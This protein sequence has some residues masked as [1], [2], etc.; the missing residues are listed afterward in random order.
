MGAEF[1][2]G[3][4][5]GQPRPAPGLAR[6]LPVIDLVD[7]GQEAPRLLDRAG[8]LDRVLGHPVAKDLAK[9]LLHRAVQIVVRLEPGDQETQVEEGLRQ[10]E[11][12]RGD[13]AAET[14]QVLQC[15]AK[16]ADEGGGRIVFPIAGTGGDIEHVRREDRV[17]R[18][19]ADGRGAV[20]DDEVIA[21]IGQL[22]EEARD[23]GNY[24][25]TTWTLRAARDGEYQLQAYWPSDASNNT[26]AR[27]EI[28]VNGTSQTVVINQ[29]Q[30]HQQW[31]D[32]STLNLT[33]DQS[34]KVILSSQGDGITVADTLQLMPT[35][36]I[37]NTFVW[38]INVPESG[39]YHVYAHWP[40]RVDRASNAQ[41][42]IAADTELTNVIVDQRKDGSQWNRIATVQFNVAELNEVRLAGLGFGYATADAIR[43]EPVPVSTEVTSGPQLYYIHNDHLGTPRILTDQNMAKVWEIHTTP[44]GE[45]HQEIAS[46]IEQIKAFPGQYRDGETGYSQNYFRDYDPSL[47][48]Y[49]QSDPIGL[50]GGLNTY[51]YVVGNPMKYSDP[52]G[53]VFIDQV[54]GGGPVIPPRVM[55]QIVDSAG[56]AYAI[57]YASHFGDDADWDDWDHPDEEDYPVWE[58][59]SDR[60]S[61]PDKIDEAMALECE[62]DSNCYEIAISIDILVRQLKFRRYDFQRKGGDPQHIPFYE[63]VRA[64]LRELMNA[65]DQ[66]G[67]PYNPEAVYEVNKTIFTPTPDYRL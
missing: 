53:L 23:G 38:P 28:I 30:F 51:G 35:A 64:K 42:Q 11:C 25:T 47:G 66:Q 50:N 13:D 58:P 16:L 39:Q 60:H 12:P 8:E 40:A 33:A 49:I 1:L 20:E 59:D 4:I 5:E 62:T 45:V 65:A 61:H 54:G 2:I 63:G 31:A 17:H 19:V 32:L 57:W 41:Y 67:C 34:V 37:T 26:Q 43:I 9:G 44:F 3:A 10:G 6:H 48:R 22:I 7:R 18:L 29:T 46:G 36:E 56:A 14:T 52:Q 15:F 55:Q 21:V 27:Y 24:A